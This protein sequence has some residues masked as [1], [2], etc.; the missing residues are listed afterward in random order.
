MS[1]WTADPAVCAIKAIKRECHIMGGRDEVMSRSTRVA[2]TEERG[3]TVWSWGHMAAVKDRHGVRLRITDDNGKGSHSTLTPALSVNH[4]T[5]ASDLL[6]AAAVNAG[7]SACGGQT[8]LELLWEELD[9]VV[10]RLMTGQEADDGRDP[11][12]AEGMALALA[13]MQNPYRVSWE[14]VRDQAVLRW[15]QAGE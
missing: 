15:E 13:I 11:G 8:L 12:R 5:V 10:D 3:A 4:A 7:S 2:R 6:R 9:A 14:A 1:N